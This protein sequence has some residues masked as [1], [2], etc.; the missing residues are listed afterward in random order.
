MQTL[1]PSVQWK[2]AVIPVLVLLVLTGIFYR[3]SALY[4]VSIWNQWEQGDYGHGYL[5]MAISAYLVFRRRRIILQTSPCPSAVALLPLLLS[6]AVWLVAMLTDVRIV[7]SA[8]LLGVLGAGLWAVLGW[9]TLRSIAFP[10]LFLALALPVWS[11]ISPLLQQITAESVFFLIGFIDVP[12]LKQD[13]FIVLPAGRLAIQEACS[14]L[15]FVL[16]ATTLGALF[17][18]LNYTSLYARLWIVLVAI[19]AAVFMNIIRVMI[20]V[21][22]A[23]QTDMQHP[24]VDDHLSLGWYLFAAMVVVLLFIDYLVHRFRVLRSADGGGPPAGDRDRGQPCTSRRVT[25]VGVLLSIVP[26][27]VSGP[28]L[29]HVY[30]SGEFHQQ[31]VATYVPPAGLNGWSGPLESVDAWQPIYH[32]ASTLKKMYTRDDKQVYVHIAYYASQSQDRELI[33]DLNTVSGGDWSAEYLN[34]QTGVAGGHNVLWQLLISPTGEQRLVYYWYNVGDITTTNAYMAKLLQLYGIL[35]GN[36]QAM[37][38]TLAVDIREN[39][40]QEAHQVL[41]RFVSGHDFSLEYS[42]SLVR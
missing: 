21:V 36:T 42:G 30:R 22:L 9:N 6:V 3:E 23:Y 40:L 1:A 7:Q 41:A 20:V 31:G 29:L 37:A 38:V 25:Q 8:A 15:R 2:A 13:N 28:V 10:L 35:T 39:G 12:A 24:L 34:A 32:G 16:A 19:A 4:L 11:V 26:V 18:Y 27:L 5:V 17:A 14:G 33:N